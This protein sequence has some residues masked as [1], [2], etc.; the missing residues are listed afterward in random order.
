[1]GHM[2]TL[3]DGISRQLAAAALAASLCSTLAAQTMPPDEPQADAAK[4]AGL[5]HHDRAFFRKAATAGAKEIAVSQAVMDNLTNT[6]VKAF[7][8]TMVIDHTAVAGQLSTLADAKGVS[9]PPEDTSVTEAW[10]KKTG[11]VDA[12]YVKEMVSDHL[13]AVKLFEGASKSSD[14]DVAAFAQKILP[15]L[16]HHLMMAQDLAKTV[17]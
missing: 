1:M 2:K 14:P 4:E 7:A 3:F 15:T 13:D 16:Q 11:D 17:N 5:S 8:Q 10:S 9:L 12:K 6:Q